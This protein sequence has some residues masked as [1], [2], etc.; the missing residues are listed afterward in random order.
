MDELAQAV[1]AAVLANLRLANLADARNEP[2][3][4]ENI[5]ASAPGYTGSE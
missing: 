5:R 4:A 1:L 2:E 3:Y